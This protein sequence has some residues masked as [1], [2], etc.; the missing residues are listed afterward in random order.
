MAF[1][2]AIDCSVILAETPIWDPRLKKLY[3]TDLFKGTV[4][5]YDPV[6]RQDECVETN[7]VIGS[8]IPCETPDRLLVAVDDGMML[9][10]FATG[11]LELV[12]APQPN[13]GEFRYND[14]RCDSA[15]RIFTSTVSKFFTEPNFDPDSMAG[16]FY[17]VDTDGTVVTLVDKLVQ[18]NTIFV[19]SKNENL[20]AI[21]T[22]NKKLLRFDYSLAKGASGEPEVVISFD[23]MPDG[24][25]LDADDNIYV[26]HWSDKRQISVWSLK[27]YSLVKTIPFPVKN[28]CC[29]GFAG[30]DLRD[31]YVATSKFWLPEGDSDFDNGAG[32]IFKTRC[33]VPGLPEH[34]YK[35][36]SLHSQA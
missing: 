11:H 24:A 9:L 10:D 12:A 33:D 18:Y 4:H 16:K 20:Y 36:Q 5:R 13:T 25:S 34:F 21:D 35:D 28:I 6:T 8:A 32:G 23:D 15:G 30:D 31:F 2:L 14:T 3:W 29:G 1:E 27:N 19:D 26:C 17:M 7:S 22:Y